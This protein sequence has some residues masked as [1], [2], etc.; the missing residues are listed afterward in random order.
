[1]WAG[2]SGEL[3]IFALKDGYQSKYPAHRDAILDGSFNTDKSRFVTAGHDGKMAIWDLARISPIAEQ[4]VDLNLSGDWMSA[5]DVE[6]SGRYAVA[7]DTKGW[8]HVVDLQGRDTIR[9][10]QTTANRLNDLHFNA[11]GSELAV[12][13]SSPSSSSIGSASATQYQIE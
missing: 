12:A 1:M 11:N 5:L 7:G 4:S 2:D 8:L 10:I 9:S 6:P 3:G 13:T